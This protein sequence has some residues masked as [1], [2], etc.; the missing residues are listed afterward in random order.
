MDDNTLRQRWETLE[1]PARIYDV[2]TSLEPLD[3][4]IEL[5]RRA[6]TVI[7]AGNP[8]WAGDAVSMRLEH[9]AH[10]LTVYRP[11]GAVQWVDN[12]RWQ[13]DDG[14]SDMRLTDPEAFDAAVREA[15]RLGLPGEDEFAPFRVTRL[16]ASSCVRGQRPG[17]PRVIDV[18]VILK[19]RL[20][21]LDFEGQGGNIVIYLGPDGELTGFQRVARRVEKVRAPVSGWRSLDDVL[22]ETEEHL[23]LRRDSGFTV[24]G[25]RSGYL[26]LGRL[27]E[28]TV[29]QPVY[30]LAL[31]LGG[32][33]RERGRGQEEG[34]GQEQGREEEPE[35]RIEH[36]VPA[37]LNNV[38]PLVPDAEPDIPETPRTTAY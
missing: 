31:R 12:S 35:R 25:A 18:G 7:P 17:E 10:T 9:G 13:V 3:D 1:T 29:I 22:A 24:D 36:V 38:A 27:E 32:P 33:V 34:R 4:T 19:R 21:G 28:Q 6:G 30:V 11:S 15:D 14:T 26:E 23:R 20:D 37:A 8:S 16:R 2:D 5:A